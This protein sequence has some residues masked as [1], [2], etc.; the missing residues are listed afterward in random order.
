ML[1]FNSNVLPH[2]K[3][4]KN[5]ITVAFNLLYKVYMNNTDRKAPLSGLMP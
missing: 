5:Y 1:T 3:K 4:K 2:L